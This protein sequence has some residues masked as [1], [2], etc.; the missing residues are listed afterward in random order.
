MWDHWICRSF[1]T[2]LDMLQ[3]KEPHTTLARRLGA[4]RAVVRADVRGVRSLQKY[5]VQMD[6][7]PLHAS[8]RRVQ[9]LGQRQRQRFAAES[10]DCGQGDDPERLEAGEIYFGLEVGLRR[11]SAR[12]VHIF[13]ISSI[14]ICTK[15]SLMCVRAVWQSCSD[16]TVVA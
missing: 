14:S 13:F 11:D 10:G 6:D 5:C 7:A 12:S 15:A 16:V 4:R 9:V 8:P 2:A 3:A 1:D